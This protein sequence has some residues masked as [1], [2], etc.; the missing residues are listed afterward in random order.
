MVAP[1]RARTP[2]AG[3][4]TRK[5][6]ITMQT[7]FERLTEV[8]RSRRLSQHI[9]DR[10]CELLDI[11]YAAGDEHALERKADIRLPK[12]TISEFTYESFRMAC[13]KDRGFLTAFCRVVEG[14]DAPNRNVWDAVLH[15]FMAAGS[16]QTACTLV[17]TA[18]ETGASGRPGWQAATCELHSRAAA[19]RVALD[20]P[21]RLAERIDEVIGAPCTDLMAV[22]LMA[23]IFRYDRS[24]WRDWVN[25]CGNAE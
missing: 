5:K 1:S 3:P 8:E 20:A 25:A 7:F 22:L 12:I 21:W 10:C 24:L 2:G 18:N 9:R 14:E 16:Y 11:E 19:A 4:F 15:G 17:A 6:P 13:E 23:Y